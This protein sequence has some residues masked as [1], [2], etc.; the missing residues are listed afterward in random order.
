MDTI[1]TS[2]VFMN[3]KDNIYIVNVPENF[4]YNEKSN[5]ISLEL[6]LHTSNIDPEINLPLN[7][8]KNTRLYDELLGV[9]NSLGELINK[10]GEIYEVK[11]KLKKAAI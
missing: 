6:Y 4:N 7:H 10:L 3:E 5:F 1:I 2:E 9:A 8:K 11:K